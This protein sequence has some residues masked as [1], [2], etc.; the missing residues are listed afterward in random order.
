MCACDFYPLV[1]AFDCNLI[2]LDCSVVQIWGTALIVKIDWM[3]YVIAS[4]TS[5]EASII[6]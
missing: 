3:L 6:S 1:G 5:R 4:K 2:V